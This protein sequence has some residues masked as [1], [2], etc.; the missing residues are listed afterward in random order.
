MPVLICVRVRI[1]KLG[2]VAL[3]FGPL[4]RCVRIDTGLEC[5]FNVGIVVV[6]VESDLG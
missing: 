3:V 6:G 5:N 1:S 2:I 4:G